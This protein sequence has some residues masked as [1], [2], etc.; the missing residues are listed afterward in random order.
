MLELTDKDLKAIA[1]NRVWQQR[2]AKVLFFGGLCTA[3]AIFI[4]VLVLTYRGVIVG[5]QAW[6]TPL[7]FIV[8]FGCIVLPSIRI[9]YYQKAAYKQVKKEHNGN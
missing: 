8:M 4:L 5:T 6:S 7:L 3:I 1:N 9:H 2:R